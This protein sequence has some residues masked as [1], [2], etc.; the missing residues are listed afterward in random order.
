MR[1]EQG[2]PMSKKADF[3]AEE[4][5]SLTQAPTLSALQVVAAQRGGTIRESLAVGRTYAEARKHSGE[6]PLLDE[7]VASPPSLKA[8]E[9]REMGGDVKSHASRS[10][11]E[12]LG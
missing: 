9:M 6:S 1:T 10:R 11:T 4:W 12:A 3:N 8:E 7:I 5:E 2:D